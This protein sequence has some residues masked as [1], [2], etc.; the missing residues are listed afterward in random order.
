MFA[1]L[2]GKRIYS[3]LNG[4]CPRCHEGDFY[5]TKHAYAIKNFGKNY[6]SCSNCNFKYEKEPGFFY[7]AMYVSY[8]F[9]VALSVAIGVAIF[10][11]LPDAS[12][13]VYLIAIISGLILLMP[14]SFRFSRIIWSNLFQHYVDSEQ[15]ETNRER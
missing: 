8:G 3:I 9:T 2:K 11:L 15:L 10:V 1:S 7:G 4:K 5:M 12:Y 6:E 13:K 14:I